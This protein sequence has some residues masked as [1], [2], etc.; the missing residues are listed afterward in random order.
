MTTV[1]GTSATPVTARRVS[2]NHP[3]LTR[4][5]NGV[6][7]QAI[8]DGSWNRLAQTWLPG[9]SPTPPTATDPAHLPRSGPGRVSQT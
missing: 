5:V 2:L 4:F 3:D 7:A 6:L 1:D 9:L 8:A